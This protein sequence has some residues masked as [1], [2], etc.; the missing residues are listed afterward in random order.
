MT[1]PIKPPAPPIGTTPPSTVDAPR[2]PSRADF[3]AEALTTPES[4]TQRRGAGEVGAVDSALASIA[5]DL[6][7]GRLSPDGAV[8]ALVGRA[9]QSPMAAALSPSARANLESVI[10]AQL[11]DD[12]ALAAL[13]ADLG[14][15]R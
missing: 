2:D 14:R 6:K 7:S 15:G 1:G 3:R 4:P 13:V 8:E 5:N 12:P 9:L 11:A 10:R